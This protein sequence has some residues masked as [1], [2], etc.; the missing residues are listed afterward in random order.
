[1]LTLQNILDENP[2]SIWSTGE[3]LLFR[4]GFAFFLLLILPLDWK[5]WRQLFSTHWGHFQD[6]FHLV[7][8]FPHFISAYKWGIASFA[9]V[10]LAL[11]FSLVFSAAWPHLDQHQTNY[12]Q[13][14]DWLR[15]LLRY[16]LGLALISYG[17]IQLFPLQFPT[18]TLSDLNTNYVDFLPWKIYYLT[19][20]AASA[21]YEEVLGFFEI[22]SGLLLFWRRFTTIGA[23]IATGILLNVV[24]ANF[25]YQLGDHVYATFLF[26][27]AL[28][29]LGNDSVRIFDLLVRRR[30][31][32]AERA[33]LLV[34]P[35]QFKTVRLVSRIAVLLFLVTYAAETYAAYNSGSWPYPNTAG[36]ADSA[37]L[38]NVKEFM[39]NGNT[40]PYSQID[41]VRW[42]NVV[43][44]K[45]NTISIRIHRPVT[46]H[47]ANPDVAY[48]PSDERDYELAGNGGRHFYRYTAD[49][50][51]NRIHLAGKNDPNES[52]SFTFTRP[53]A[54]QLVLTGTDEKGN[55]LNITLEK[56]DKQYLLDK[57]RRKPLTLY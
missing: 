40:L 45:W 38:Y 28:V 35:P 17:L 51:Q 56:V 27:I 55:T 20:S 46:I 33:Y 14:Y 8:Y 52:Y 34:R 37:G 57:G 32:Y 54:N 26:G 3:K 7:N 29:L 31:A 10:G 21:H 1:M 9:N 18:L 6:L 22:L 53:A 43:F 49:S 50:Q 30:K 16:K 12:A 23:A 19:N 41:P 44:E 2:R 47:L 36:L 11:V 5:F 24:V 42:Q 39:I 25:A 15:V 4:T 48:L 13:L